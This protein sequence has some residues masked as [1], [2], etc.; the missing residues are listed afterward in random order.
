[1][2]NNEL[3]SR[4]LSDLNRILAAIALL[5]PV[6]LV[7]AP[8]AESPAQPRPVPTVFSLTLGASVN[9]GNT[10]NE[11]ADL[12]LGLT[13]PFCGL[14]EYELGAEGH[15]S[16]AEPNGDGCGKETTVKNGEIDG[17]ISSRRF[18]RDSYFYLESSL[19]ADDVA[20]VDFRATEGI[21]GGFDLYRTKKARLS[22]EAGV[23][24]MW[25]KINAETDYHTMIRL[26]HLF[27]YS[28]DAG[29]SLKGQVECLP[30][31][32][33]KD[34]FLVNA[35]V[36]LESPLNKWASLTLTVKNAFNSRPGAGNDKNDTSA[37]AGLRLKL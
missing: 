6:S 9:N 37:I 26:A 12:A 13:G 8:A 19:F 25:E 29:A 36:T 28:F 21:G 10:D 1:M 11:N 2:K 32:D 16:K 3:R 17:R 30:A 7:A 23:S 4:A 18:A 33:D 20:N 5:A 15:L 24:P 22:V 34:K 35:S 27:V 14:G 31:A